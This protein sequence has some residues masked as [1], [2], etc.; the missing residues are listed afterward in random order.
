RKSIFARFPKTPLPC[1]SRACCTCP[2]PTWCREGVSTRCT[3]GTATSFRSACCAM[4]KALSPRTW[5]TISS[6]KSASMAGFSMPTVHL[7]ETP[8]RHHV[9]M[10]QVEQALLAHGSG[11]F[12]KRTEIDFLKVFGRHVVPQL[13]PD[14]FQ[15]LIA[16]HVDR[17]TPL[18]TG[19]KLG[20]RRSRRQRAVGA[21]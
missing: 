3:V 4:A 7:V 13:L 21:G 10:G 5:P 17:P 18:G 11:V 6:T 15:I 16:R 8:A 2:I 1:A 9:G 19:L 14:G 12:G 20:I